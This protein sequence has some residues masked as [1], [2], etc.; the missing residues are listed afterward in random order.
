MV[1]DVY[2][3]GETE[4]HGKGYGMPS[5][6]A[7]FVAFF[8]TYL[9]LFLLLRHQPKPGTQNTLPYWQRLAVSLLSFF[10]AAAVSASRIYLNYHKP[11]QVYVGVAVGA[12]CAV[13]WFVVTGLARREGVLDW[14]L[15]SSAARMV[16]LR[17]LVVEEDLVQAGWERSEDRRRRRKREVSGVNGSAVGSWKKKA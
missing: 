16:R 11:R 14:I 10:W 6:H 1:A 9:S 2:F 12:G 3:L 13:A 15:E 4:M 17:D 7:Q 8:A 5:S